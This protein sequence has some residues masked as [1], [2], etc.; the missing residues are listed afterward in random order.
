[1]TNKPFYDWQAVDGTGKYCANSHKT[2]A[3]P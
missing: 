1:M 3:Q 2:E